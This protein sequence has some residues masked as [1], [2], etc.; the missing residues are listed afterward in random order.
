MLSKFSITDKSY[1]VTL[2]MPKQAAQEEDSP[3]R[4]EKAHLKTGG[5]NRRSL[6]GNDINDSGEKANVDNEEEEEILVPFGNADLQ[7]LTN[8][9]SI[10]DVRKLQ[11]E[12]HYE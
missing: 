10:N 2:C 8:S 3:S 6:V 7:Q 4:Q 5:N 12:I 1:G 9:L 11:E